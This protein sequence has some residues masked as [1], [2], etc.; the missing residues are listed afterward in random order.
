MIHI[1]A[2]YVDAKDSRPANEAP[3]RHGPAL[4]THDIEIDAVDRRKTPAV[5]LGKIPDGSDIPKGADQLSET[6]YLERLSDYQAWRAECEAKVKE[7]T[8]ADMRKNVEALRDEKLAHYSHDFG[9][10]YGTLTLQLRDSHDRTSFLTL[11]SACAKLIQAGQGDAPVN[12]RTEENVTVQ[13]TAA[14]ASAVLASMADYGQQVMLAS[15]QIKDA[16]EQADNPE[17]VDIEQGWPQ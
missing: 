4:P 9:G 5:I 6:E 11:D 15:W 8:R 10:T 16:I 1:A 12:I 14:E 17:E 3:L 7:R 13:T 2:H